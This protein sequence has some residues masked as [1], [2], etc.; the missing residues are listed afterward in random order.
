MD[1]SQRVV[2]AIRP[3]AAVGQRQKTANNCLSIS[4]EETQ[5]ICLLQRLDIR[6]RVVHDNLGGN[7]IH[8]Q[9]AQ[10]LIGQEYPIKL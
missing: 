9:C 2:V 8:K 6:L 5:T 1:Q 10:A 7:L 3:K 4:S